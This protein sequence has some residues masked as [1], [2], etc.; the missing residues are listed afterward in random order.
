[1]PLVTVEELEDAINTWRERKPSPEGSEQA[2]ALC[3]EARALAN[4]YGTMIFRRTKVVD[5]ATFTRTQATAY[6]AAFADYE[7]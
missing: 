7:A 6:A 5:T 1:M 3:A 2:P 4:V